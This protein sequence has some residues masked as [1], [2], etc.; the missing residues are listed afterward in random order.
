MSKIKIKVS[1]TNNDISYKKDYDAIYNKKDKIVIYKEDKNITMKYD[2][3]NNI[4]VRT[5]PE[6]TAQYNFNEEK[7]CTINIPDINKSIEIPI[8]INRLVNNT[9]STEIEYE[10]EDQKVHYKLE[11]LD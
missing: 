9:N 5:T 7:V 10:I 4:L 3:R 6:F 11:I 8:N 2:L 1:F